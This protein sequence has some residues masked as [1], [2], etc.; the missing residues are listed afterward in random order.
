MASVLQLCHSE[1]GSLDSR[2]T[3]KIANV[4]PL[5]KIRVAADNIEVLP[6]HFVFVDRLVYPTVS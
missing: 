5:F 6:C 3:K 4:H 2:D 1:R